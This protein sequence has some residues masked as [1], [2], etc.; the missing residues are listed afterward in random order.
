MTHLKRS[1]YIQY[2]RINSMNAISNSIILYIHKTSPPTALTL[3]MSSS[4]RNCQSM[5]LSLSISVNSTIPFTTSL[6]TQ[7]NITFTCVAS[8]AKLAKCCTGIC[9][10]IYSKVSTVCDSPFSSSSQ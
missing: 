6:L 4:V 1:I 7:E 3:A 5:G 2:A 8:C 10:V 9:T